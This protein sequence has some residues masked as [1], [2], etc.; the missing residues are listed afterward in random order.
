MRKASLA[1]MVYAPHLGC[2]THTGIWV[3]LPGEALRPEW[4]ELNYLYQQSVAGGRFLEAPGFDPP[5]GH[6]GCQAVSVYNRQGS[7]PR[8]AIGTPTRTGALLACTPP[9]FTQPRKATP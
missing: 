9:L 3:R 5:A 6:Q 8:Y 2:G 1:E 7:N 4:I